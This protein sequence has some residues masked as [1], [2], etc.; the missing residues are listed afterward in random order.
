[1]HYVDF[2]ARDNPRD[3]LSQTRLQRDFVLGHWI[4]AK[5]CEREDETV[6]LFRSEKTHLKK[7]ARCKKTDYLH[8]S[9]ESTS[10]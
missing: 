10:A 1:M 6:D 4:A 7:V 9:T 3:L 5:K 8:D 2:L